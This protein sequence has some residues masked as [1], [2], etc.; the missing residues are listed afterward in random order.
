MKRIVRS[1]VSWR[2]PVMRESLSEADQAKKKRPYE[3]CAMLQ[4]LRSV[5]A[6]EQIWQAPQMAGGGLS[7]SQRRLLA[8]G[9]STIVKHEP[10]KLIRMSE[11]IV[12]LT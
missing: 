1:C 3:S 11:E 6:Q 5:V 10:V 7:V 8:T 12:D 4:L 2:G 9:R